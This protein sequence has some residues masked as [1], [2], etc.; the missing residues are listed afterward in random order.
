MQKQGFSPF[1]PSPMSSK[2][3]SDLDRLSRQPVKCLPDG[4]C[5]LL[6]L[7]FKSWPVDGKHLVVSHDNLAIDDNRIHQIR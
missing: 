7:P 6:R 5:H 4:L 1:V 2:Y 3:L